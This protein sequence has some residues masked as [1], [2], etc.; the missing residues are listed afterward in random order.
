MSD[1]AWLTIK[2]R[3]CV[4]DPATSN[5]W[6]EEDVHINVAQITSLKDC[7]TWIGS[8]ATLTFG[9]NTKISLSDGKTYHVHEGIASLKAR[10]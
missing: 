4:G 7:A 2:Q 1:A 5:N 10:M 3:D 9:V 8:P 6:Y